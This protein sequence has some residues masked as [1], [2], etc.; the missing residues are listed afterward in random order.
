MQENKSIRLWVLR[1]IAV[2]LMAASAY[3][4]WYTIA[5]DKPRDF[6]RDVTNPKRGDLLGISG[7]FE[8]QDGQRISLNTFAGKNVIATFVFKDCGMSCPMIMNDLRLFEKDNPGFAETGVFLIFTFEDHRSKAQELRD[9]LSKYRITG[10]HW[11]VLTADGQTIKRLA[12]TFDLQY[13]KGESGRYIYA[14]SN[15]FIVADKSGKVRREFRGIDNN[16]A[17]FFDEVRKSL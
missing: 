11:R 3:I 6:W 13:N 9:F 1:G 7:T 2:S 16:K 14:H 15:V 17:K 5:S 12:D 10:R 8:D 4:A